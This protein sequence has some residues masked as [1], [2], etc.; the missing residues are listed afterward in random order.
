MGLPLEQLINP[1]DR[2]TIRTRLLRALQGV[3][4]T[5]RPSGYA[6]GSVYASGIPIVETLLLVKVMT[7]GQLGTA[8]VQVSTNGGVSYGATA[9]IPSNGLL[10]VS[11]TGVTLNF[12]NGPTGVTESFKVGNIFGIQLNLSDF[13]PTSWQPGSTPLTLLETDAQLSEDIY[14]LA[15]AIAKGGFLNY[16][17]DDW[18]DLVGENLYNLERLGG[19]FARGSLVLTDAGGAGPFV[20]AAGSL[21]A[22]SASGLLYFNESALTIPASGTVTATFKAEKKGQAYNVGNNT[23]TALATPLAG[24]TVNNPNPGS[25]TW[26]L[27]QGTDPESNPLYRSRCRARWPSLG[28]ATATPEEVYDLWARTAS[29]EVTRT[30]P[31]PSPTVPGEV[32]LFLAGASGPVSSQA[33]DDVDDYIQPR[34]ALTNTLL[35]Q[36]ATAFPVTVTANIYVYAGYEGQVAIEC[37]AN[38]TALFTELPL[39]GTLYVSNIIETLSLPVGV[40][41]VTV[42]APAADV[43]LTALQVATLT[44]NLTFLTV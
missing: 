10:A 40:R 30:K 18:L 42:A 43:V 8:Q 26:I 36:N 28:P 16:S 34:V 44:Q 19:T 24:V 35:V 25:G 23:I 17:E 1:P 22:R 3:G 6:P 33:V 9:T 39:G 2:E 12:S 21:W 11:G 15:V 27:T 7:A 41:N 32:E 29:A 4:F 38:L 37:A 5:Q 20:Q 13:Q 31:R 14:T